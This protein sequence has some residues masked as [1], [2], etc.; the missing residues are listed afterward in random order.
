M[1]N[2]YSLQDDTIQQ[3]NSVFKKKAFPV[4]M[5]FQF[6]G[7]SKQKHLIKISKIADSYAFILD[8]ELLV[9][10]NEDIMAVFDDESVG[11][12]IEQEIDKVSINID[13]GKI[14]MVKPDLTTF[15]SL[16]NKYGIDKIAKANNLEELYSQ[17]K[18]DQQVELI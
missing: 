10:I 14:K 1:S 4:D 9:S 8:K 7:N 15:S 11:I 18:E 3:F 5:R 17:Q 12:L 13:T 2:F 6:V 16:I